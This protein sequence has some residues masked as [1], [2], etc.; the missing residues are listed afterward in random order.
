VLMEFVQM[1]STMPI[2]SRPARQPIRLKPSGATLRGQTTSGIVPGTTH[3]VRDSS[4]ANIGTQSCTEDVAGGA[5]C[6]SCI[7]CCY[8][9]CRGTAPTDILPLYTNHLQEAAA[10]NPLRWWDDHK[11]EYPLLSSAF[12]LGWALRKFLWLTGKK[13]VR[14]CQRL[15]I[16]GM[17]LCQAF[18]KL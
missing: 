13:K 17:K 7:R 6:L 16:S 9:P 1:S 15:T 8:V 3:T 12:A 11:F 18:Q 4:R 10:F 5:G 2:Q 14:H